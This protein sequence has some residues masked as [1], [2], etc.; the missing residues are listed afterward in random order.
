MSTVKAPRITKPTRRITIGRN[1][2]WGSNSRRPTSFPALRLSGK[3]LRD[4]GFG[5]G[6]VVEIACEAGRLVITIAKE[7]KHEALQE[8]KQKEMLELG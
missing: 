6:E 8:L 1:I 3:W 5:I 4:S 2:L 7:Q